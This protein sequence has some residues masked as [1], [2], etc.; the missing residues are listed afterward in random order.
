[1]PKISIIV[2]IYK[3]QASHLAQALASAC[4]AATNDCEIHI[5]LDGEYHKEGIDILERMQATSK[6]C[7]IRISQFA[8]QGLVETLNA[9]IKKTDCAYIARH[10][11]DDVCLPDRLRQQVSAMELNASASFC[12]TQICRCDVDMKPHSLQRR[13]PL[14][15]RGQLHYASLFNNPIAHPSLLIKRQVFEEIQY[16]SVAGAEDWDLYIRLWMQ[17]HRSFNL[18]QTGLLYRIHPKQVTQQNR[19]STTLK[20]LKRKSL[21]ASIRTHNGGRLLSLSCYISEKTSLTERII[22]VKKYL[23]RQR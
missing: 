4:V 20:E 21:E 23:E 18:S 6:G 3:T 8:R 22:N 12:G 9:L 1:M 16:N 13:L 10:D 7:K 11:G 14:T 19:N 17:G 2:P 15:F 5:G